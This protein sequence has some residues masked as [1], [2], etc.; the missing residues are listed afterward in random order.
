MISGK[1]SLDLGWGEGSRIFTEQI[2]PDPLLGVVYLA[3]IL[4]GL[5][6]NEPNNPFVAVFAPLAIR[7]R[8]KLSQSAHS[9]W[10]TIHSAP[11]DPKIRT[12]L[13]Q[14]YEFLIF[15]RFKDKTDEEIWKM[16]NVLVPIEET[17]AY[18][19]IFAKGLVAGKME[20]RMEGKVE[21]KMEGELGANA[22]TLKQLLTHRFGQLPNWAVKH[23]ECANNN[24]LKKWLAGIFDMQR[25]EDLIEK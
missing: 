7:Q 8:S 12:T 21:G 5:L 18:Q 11:I 1:N 23:I 25:L 15:E 13:E 6:E 22:N 20:G 16:I 14:I 17:R 19:S 9:H 24:Q 10:Q 4:T 3:D 2:C